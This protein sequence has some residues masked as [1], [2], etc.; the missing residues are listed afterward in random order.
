MDVQEDRIF[1]RPL[2]G[3]REWDAVPEDVEQ[4]NAREEL[5]ERSAATRARGRDLPQ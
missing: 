2:G 1:L 5:M 4:L 3:G